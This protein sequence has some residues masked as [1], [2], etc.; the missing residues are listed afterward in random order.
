MSLNMVA[1]L[2]ES[3]S[4]TVIAFVMLTG[5]I[6][7]PQVDA[8]ANVDANP[9]VRVRFSI[10]GTNVSKEVIN[11]VH[12]EHEQTIGNVHVLT[13]INIANLITILNTS[14]STTHPPSDATTNP[15]KRKHVHLSPLITIPIVK[16]PRSRR[17][18]MRFKFVSK[19]E[20][21]YR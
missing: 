8:I 20:H 11:H 1:I 14:A 3:V 18:W 13:Q 16:S 4:L 7:M 5:A 2:C 10:D 15:G 17:R 12:Q 21:F 6:W 19:L 9:I